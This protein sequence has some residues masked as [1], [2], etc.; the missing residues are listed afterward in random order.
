MCGIAG[1]YGK[2]RNTPSE[3]KISNCLKLMYNRGPDDK[4]QQKIVVGD[5]TIVMLHSRLSIID[6]SNAGHQPYKGN[7][8]VVSFNGEIYNYVEQGKKLESIDEQIETNTDTEILIKTIEKYGLEEGLNQLDGMWAFAAYDYISDSFYLCRDV[9]GEKPLYYYIDNYGGIFFASNVRYLFSIISDEVDIDY[10]KIISYLKYGFHEMYSDDGTFFKNI[11]SIDSGSFLKLD[12][13]L[14]VVKKYYPNIID[15]LILNDVD[16]INYKDSVNIVRDAVLTSFEGAY[17]SDVDMSALLSGG[18]DSGLIASIAS[19]IFGIN[20]KYYSA[21]ASSVW[22]DESKLI[23]AVTDKYKLDHTFVEINRTETTEL[24]IDLIVD[25]A[26]PLPSNTSLVYAALN[27]VISQD[28]SKVLLTGSG[29]D[30][31]FAGYYIHHLDYLVDIHNTGHFD[32]SYKEWK[33]YITPFIRNPDLKNYN[34]YY[35]ATLKG[36]KWCDNSE[37]DKYYMPGFECESSTNISAIVG[38]DKI[39]FLKEK[40]LQD[41]FYNTIPSQIISADQISMYFSIENRAPFLSSTLLR[42]T[43]RIP[44]KHFI[45]NGYG[46]SL[47]R[48]AFDDI[49]PAEIKNA[50]EKVG[51]NVPVESVIN[52]RS[53]L[54]ID[55]LKNNS[56]INK[57][58]DINKVLDD[59]RKRDISNATSKLL[60]RLVNVAIFTNYYGADME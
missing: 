54:I 56:F 53:N 60:F 48:D 43:L 5:R 9:F 25:S 30:E 52:V 24:L 42:K 7:N 37:D 1:Y 22:Y 17:R 26:S 50:R 21:E 15:E 35:C 19:N 51:F 32:R 45:K 23:S 12:S 46:K 10:G 47:L 59:V 39:G 27:K 28:G 13:K 38:A 6:L 33:K 18:V 44:S 4:G 29:G 40:L 8:I 34:K 55:M 14:R 16:S 49:L 31:L 11:K 57:Y 20:M 36:E 2:S 58:Y 3:K 41:L